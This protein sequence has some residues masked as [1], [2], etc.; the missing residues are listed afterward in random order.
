MFKH[1]ILTL[2][3]LSGA[4]S[5]HATDAHD[6][7]G[8]A[9]LQL[10]AAN[11]PGDLVSDAFMVEMIDITLQVN[12]QDDSLDPMLREELADARVRLQQRVAA[13]IMDEP[14]LLAT[15]G[16]CH[17]R[18]VQDRNCDTHWARVAELAGDNGYLHLLLMNHAAAKGDDMLFARHAALAAEAETFEPILAGVFGSLYERYLLVPESLWSKDMELGGP[19]YQAGVL[20]MA[21]VAVSALPSYQHFMLYCKAADVDEQLL[22]VAAAKR[23]ATD[24]STLLDRMIGTAMLREHGTDEQKA[25]AKEQHRQDQWLS[26]G[27]WLS[28][29]ELDDTQNARYFELFVEQGEMGAIRYAN[30]A[31]GR[32]LEAP[33]DWQPSAYG[34]ETN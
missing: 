32:A 34:A 8:A 5:A 26:R 19:H 13:A 15:V 33:A 20:A 17:G 30:L 21:N 31:L 7:N 28:E 22:C 1:F 24:S 12:A 25:W 18:Y 23:L 2:L 16:D 14:N 9:R 27:L 11:A 3:V 10:A 6:A 29:D 4:T